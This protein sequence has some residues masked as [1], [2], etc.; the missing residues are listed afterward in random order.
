MRG[1]D[2]YYLVEVLSSYLKQ[3]T[4]QLNVLKLLLDYKTR[5]FFSPYLHRNK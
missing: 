1:T 2:I 4:K 5:F 3:T